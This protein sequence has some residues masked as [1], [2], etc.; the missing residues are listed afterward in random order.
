MIDVLLISM[1][2]DRAQAKARNEQLRV[3]LSFSFFFLLSS[4][5]SFI[6]FSS[7]RICFFSSLLKFS[8]Q[9][10]VSAIEASILAKYKCVDDLQVLC[11]MCDDGCEV[12]GVCEVCDGGYDV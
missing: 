3:G 5:I 7:K 8:S 9:S 11:D 6:R 1:E 10:E 12:C 4:F 2:A